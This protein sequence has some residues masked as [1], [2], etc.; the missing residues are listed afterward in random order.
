MVRQNY[1]TVSTNTLELIKKTSISATHEDFDLIHQILGRSA[2]LKEEII[3]S[4]ISSHILNDNSLLKRFLK[5]IALLHAAGAKILLIHEASDALQETMNLFG[6]D[7]AN[8]HDAQMSD[9]KSMNII[10]MVLSG[11]LNKKIVSMLCEIGCN[12]LGISGKD[13]NLIRAEQKLR[14]KSQNNII[15]IGFSSDPIM[16]NA[17]TIITLLESNIAIVISPIASGNNNT[18]CMIDAN[19]ATA[20]IASAL[21]AKYLILPCDDPNINDAEGIIITDYDRH[22]INQMKID[23]KSSN[24]FKIIL[25]T[26]C[27]ALDNYVDYICITDSKKPDAILRTIFCTEKE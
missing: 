14:K 21:A 2:T 19:I 17:E 5:N 10:E 12:T 15:N 24:D 23:S 3:V 13:C 18:T 27:S 7:Q 8:F 16:I 20:L 9:H 4:K 11:H 26:A 1:K 22:Q 6:V 25:D